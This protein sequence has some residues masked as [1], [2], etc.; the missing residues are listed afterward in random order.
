MTEKEMVQLAA[1]MENHST[2]P[3]AK[4]VQAYAHDEHAT[5]PVEEVEELPGFGLKGTIHG[6]PILVGNPRLLDKYPLTHPAHLSD[7]VDPLVAVAVEGTHIRVV[8]IA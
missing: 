5:I 3:I 8:T 1:A 6:Q 7:I 4:A 2:H